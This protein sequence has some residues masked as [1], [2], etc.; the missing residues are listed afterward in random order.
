MY[1]HDL[2]V[3]VRFAIPK[4]RSQVMCNSLKRNSSAGMA[5]YRRGWQ[6]LRPATSFSPSG[7]HS[8]VQGVLDPSS[9]LLQ[10]TQ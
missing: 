10:V 1:F 5:P 6:A 7:P 2:R 3:Y 8:L 9:L 4:R